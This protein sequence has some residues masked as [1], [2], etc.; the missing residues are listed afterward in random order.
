MTLTHLASFA[1]VTVLTSKTSHK[2]WRADLPL[3]AGSL[4]LAHTLP[5]HPVRIKTFYLHY[6]F[7]VK[8]FQKLSVRFMKAAISEKGAFQRVSMSEIS[9]VAEAAMTA[10]CGYSPEQN[11]QPRHLDYRYFFADCRVSR[12]R[13]NGCIS[14]RRLHPLAP[15]RWLLD[16]R[17][18]MLLNVTFCV[19]LEAINSIFQF[20]MQIGVHMGYIL[21]KQKYV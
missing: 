5:F 12:N 20:S 7:V 6:V 17:L 21:A 1:R 4:L 16:R 13:A 8:C 11:T 15:G 18:E 10:A 19:L 14:L 3:A 9:T 2:M